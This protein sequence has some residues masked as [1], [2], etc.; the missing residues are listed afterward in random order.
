[1]AEVPRS[2]TRVTSPVLRMRCQRRSRS[3][4]FWNMSTLMDLR[5]RRASRSHLRSYAVPPTSG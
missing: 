5:R 4:A 1:M 3:M 2:M